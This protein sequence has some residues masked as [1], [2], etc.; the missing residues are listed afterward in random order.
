MNPW[1]P[2]EVAKPQ[3]LENAID[4]SAV[5]RLWDTALSASFDG[6]AVWVHGDVTPSN[7]LTSG[8]RL[9]GS[10]TRKLRCGRPSV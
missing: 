2:G 5:L 9:V 6:G 7:L 8:N 1:L 10:S 4:A 3:R